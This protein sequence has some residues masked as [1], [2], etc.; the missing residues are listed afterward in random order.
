MR[1][2]KKRQESERNEEEKR[3]M[4]T[5]LHKTRRDS[6]ALEHIKGGALDESEECNPRESRL[7]QYSQRANRSG[8]N[9]RGSEWIWQN[10]ENFI[11]QETAQFTRQWILIIQSQTKEGSA[12]N[13]NGDIQ[14]LTT[15]DEGLRERAKVV[16]ESV[17][18]FE[19]E[20]HWTRKLLRL[21][22]VKQR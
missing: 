18:L 11:F 6:R 2:T 15:K 14:R 3:K 5:Y 19:C 20:G 16:I 13:C 9:S 4:G 10:N 17:P 21:G 12:L 7:I 1:A 22:R 8:S